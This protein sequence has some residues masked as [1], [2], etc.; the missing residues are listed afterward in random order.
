LIYLVSLFFSVIINPS[1][2]G[3]VIGA[4]KREIF[5]LGFLWFSPLM[6][7]MILAL[8]FSLYDSIKNKDYKAVLFLP[9]IYP[10]I[11]LSYGA[12]MIYGY[13]KKLKR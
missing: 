9:F 5:S 11:H 6:F 2:I 4:G 13:L 12:G 3:S 1:I 7:Y 10:I 8:L